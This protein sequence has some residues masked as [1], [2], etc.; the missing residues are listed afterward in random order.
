MTPFFRSNSNCTPLIRAKRLGKSYIWLETDGELVITMGPH[1]P[2]V[3]VVIFLIIGGTYMSMELITFIP[4]NRGSFLPA[5]FRLSSI[6]FFTT[7]TALLLLTACSDPGI[8]RATPLNEKE[9]TE[10]DLAN[11]MYC[12]I[13]S[14]YQPE[15]LQIRHCQEVYLLYQKQILTCEHICLYEHT[16]I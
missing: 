11:T 1:W 7:T 5:F 2:G 12:E 13:C 14:I 10:E 9:E 4:P 6:F 3:L 16:C 8:V 15:K